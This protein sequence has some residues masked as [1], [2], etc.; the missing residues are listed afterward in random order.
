MS[1]ERNK[2]GTL[3]LLEAWN[4]GDIDA[5]A[6]L[7]HPDA[8]Y[9]DPVNPGAGPG[10]YR[11]FVKNA[12]L[13]FPDMKLTVGTVFGE[14]D[15]SG[16]RWTAAGTN[17]GPFMGRPP[18]GRRVVITGNTIHRWKDGKLLQIWSEWSALAMLEQLGVVPPLT[19]KI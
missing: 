2:A 7:F 3:R 4:R 1:V 13:G 9:Y 15:Y 8:I 14:G 17:T 16:A 18:T 6:D 19:R 12:R 10:S 5:L 11:D